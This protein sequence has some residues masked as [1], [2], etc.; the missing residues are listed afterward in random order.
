MEAGKQGRTSRRPAFAGR[1]F[2][3]VDARSLSRF[4]ASTMPHAKVVYRRTGLV[5]GPGPVRFA[6]FPDGLGRA[7]KR[8]WRRDGKFGGRGN[9]SG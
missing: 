6:G 1:F 7:I 5:Q 9:F 4:E 2:R 3:V 8:L